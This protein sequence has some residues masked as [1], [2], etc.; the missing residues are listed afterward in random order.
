M[1]PLAEAMRSCIQAKAS[2]ASKNKGAHM[3]GNKI[4]KALIAMNDGQTHGVPIGPDTSLVV[5]EIVLAA[6][7]ELLETRCK[8][9]VRGFRA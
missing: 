2:L 3:L 5:A 8:G 9:L 1:P 7:D 6:A 4:D